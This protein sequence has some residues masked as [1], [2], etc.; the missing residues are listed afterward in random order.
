MSTA[1]GRITRLEPGRPGVIP[2]GLTLLPIVIVA[3]W[4]TLCFA[5]YVSGWPI[6]Y[7]RGNVGLVAL[8]FGSTLV[9]VIGTFFFIVR[10]ASFERS[11]SSVGTGKKL[12]WI[13]VAAVVAI[14]ALYAPLAEAYSGF[15][16]W[17]VLPALA[18]QSAAYELASLRISEGLGARIGLVLIQTV[19][20][21]IT[22]AAL[23]YLAFRWFESRRHLIPLVIV[24]LLAVFTSILGGRDFQLVLSAVL[25]AI[26]WMVARVRRGVGFG[27]VDAA[28]LG[29]GAVLGIVLFGLRKQSRMLDRPYCPQGAD[30]CA[31]PNA[32][33]L[34]DTI[35]VTVSSYLSQGFEGLG[36]ALDATWSFGG[37][38][39]HSPALVGLVQNFTGA[40]NGSVVTAQLDTLDWSA[41]ANWSTGFAMIANDVPW[42][43]VPVVVAIGAALL[44]I[45]WRAT[46]VRG[47][48]LSVAVFAYS[49]VGLFF[50]PMNLQLAISG[51]LYLGYLALVG[52][53]L[54]RLVA[55]A[56]RSHR[57]APEA[58]L[59][60][61]RWAIGG[62]P[63]F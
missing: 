6:Q 24:V 43:L 56:V 37:G 12:P 11:A 49:F 21:P 50:M 33:T 45:A 5:F 31:I 23:P 34:W 16:F 28:V 10:S 8:L 3:I 14:V 27:R 38:Y 52:L 15:H 22:L 54:V 25:L 19:L 58:L 20:S 40:E 41:T 47:D 61:P 35:T 60:R 29:G 4:W 26:A 44:A 30:V 62:R 46:I 9:L 1:W 7:N 48:W 55:G 57:G 32:P 39:S 53:F 18:N 59:E 36:R 17:Q 2:R 42:L 51:P 13:M 63:L